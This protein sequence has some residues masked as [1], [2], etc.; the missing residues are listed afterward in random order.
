MTALNSILTGLVTTLQSRS[1]SLKESSLRLE[2]AENQIS[3]LETRLLEKGDQV[4]EVQRDHLLSGS[5]KA[6]ELRDLTSSMKVLRERTWALTEDLEVS[7][8]QLTQLRE[9]KS[10]LERQ[11]DECREETFKTREQMTEMLTKVSGIFFLPWKVTRAFSFLPH[12]LLYPAFKIAF[13]KLA[14]IFLHLFISSHL[15]GGS[16]STK[17]RVPIQSFDRVFL[18]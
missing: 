9:S 1:T 14:P 12:P 3:D 8:S 5:D 13:L 11:V 2:T 10:D 18:Q 6:S 16:Q 4:L 7:H 17:K 15:L